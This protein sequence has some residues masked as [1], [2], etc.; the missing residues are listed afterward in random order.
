[1]STNI[2]PQAAPW[3][4]WPDYLTTSTALNFGSF[5]GF[6]YNQCTPDSIKWEFA[7]ASIR[8]SEP[9]IYQLSPLIQTFPHT[10]RYS[11]V[12]FNANIRTAKEYAAQSAQFLQSVNPEFDIPQ[13][14]MKGIFYK[15]AYNDYKNEKYDPY[16][17]SQLISIG[18]YE[19]DAQA[20][21]KFIAFPMGIAGTDLN[22]IPISESYDEPYDKE[23]RDFIPTS[24][25]YDESYDKELR[26]SEYYIGRHELNLS[27]MTTLKF[28]TPVRQI[29][30]S[31]SESWEFKF[32]NDDKVTPSLL[33]VRTATGTTFF[34]AMNTGSDFSSSTTQGSIKPIALDTVLNHSTRTSFE[35]THVAFN[36]RLY[37]EAAIV[38]CGGGVYIWRAERHQ[39]QAKSIDKYAIEI[40]RN[41]QVHEDVSL[42][43]L[44]KTC[45]YSAHPQCLYVASRERIDLFDFRNAC[46]TQP[47]NMFSTIEGD[48]IYAFQHMPYPN[49]FQ[50]ILVTDNKVVLLDQRFPKRPLLSWVHYNTDLPIGLNT[51]IDKQTSTILT[52]S[53][54][55][56]KIMAFQIPTSK[57]GLVTA[58]GYPIL[59][60]SFHTH[61]TYCRSK[62]LRI[63]NPSRLY[64]IAEEF[65][66]PQTLPP[67]ASVLLLRNNIKAAKPR[68]FGSCFSVIQLSQTGALYTQIFYSRLHTSVFPQARIHS[69]KEDMQIVEMPPSVASLQFIAD[70][71]VGTNPE[72]QLKCHQKW[73]FEKIWNYV[74]RDFKLLHNDETPTVLEI[75]SM[76]LSWEHVERYFEKYCRFCYRQKSI[77]TDTTGTVCTISYTCTEG[78]IYERSKRLRKIVP[79]RWKVTL[80]KAK[81]DA[82]IYVTKFS[83]KHNHKTSSPI[84]HSN[85]AKKTVLSNDYK[86]DVLQVFS[87][88]TQNDDISAWENF[89][90]NKLEMYRGI[91]YT[92]RNPKTLKAKQYIFLTIVNRYEI[93]KSMP[94][95]RLENRSK[96]SCAQQFGNLH[97]MEKDNVEISIDWTNIDLNA[98]LEQLS[99]VS[100]KF[101]SSSTVPKIYGFPYFIVTDD[102]QYEEV[103]DINAAL[104]NTYPLPLRNQDDEPKDILQKKIID[105][106]NGTYYSETNDKTQCLREFAIEELIR[107]LT[108]SSHALVSKYEH[109]SEYSLSSNFLPMSK[110]TPIFEPFETFSIK[111]DISRK[112][113]N[114]LSQ[115]DKLFELTPTVQALFDD[116]IIGQDV[117][118]YEYHYRRVNNKL[119]QETM[120]TSGESDGDHYL[121][122]HTSD[123]QMSAFE[124]DRIDSNEEIVTK[125]LR[126]KR[127]RKSG[128]L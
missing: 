50:S 40:I 127:S 118:E 13:E 93:L 67:L 108:F 68:S 2:K 33:A 41:P 59:V 62:Y 35:H 112:G 11:P 92:V 98:L 128:F 120:T 88:M 56:P 91:P 111:C 109:N 96:I 36:P 66:Q 9:E 82:N 20:L 125:R 1:M 72:L 70:Q 52:W 29:A 75:G 34:R 42:K 14:F 19:K 30:S 115:V 116:W 69:T 51:L 5:G 4:T 12:N 63:P 44:W 114:K 110:V 73:P 16:M 65:I 117:K 21:K 61:P 126:K 37:G 85:P 80:D 78:A 48:Q 123:D 6:V 101:C 43:D 94:G 47:L 102:N 8:N 22:L 49:S 53:K 46:S 15:E 84:F 18:Y 106:L 24:E 103:N 38:D 64:K 89:F 32:P 105:F 26:G 10:R 95:T 60:P 113:K 122:M 119:V 58:T 86:F 3:C 97:V 99:I 76:F 28:K 74:T 87:P 100:D 81:T 124:A 121:S 39:A 31:I 55:P 79:C 25:S 57:S 71:D 45:E 17:S 7:N 83:N 104:R 27:T 107:D 23:L 77:T 54:N 90:R